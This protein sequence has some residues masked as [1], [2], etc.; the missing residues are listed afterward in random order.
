MYNYELS[1]KSSV[2][3]VSIGKVIFGEVTYTQKNRGKN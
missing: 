2:G 3:E 1:V